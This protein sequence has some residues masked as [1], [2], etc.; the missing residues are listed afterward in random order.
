M[1]EVSYATLFFALLVLWA[2]GV[3]L[4]APK[5]KRFHKIFIAFAV[6]GVICLLGYLFNLWHYLGRPPFRTLGETRLWYAFLLTL[7]GLGVYAYYR[8]AWF[9]SYSLAMSLLFLFIN[10]RHQEVFDKTLMPAL[11]S[12]WFIPHVV[13]YIEAYAL[14]AAATLVALRAFL[15]KDLMGSENIQIADRL[16]RLGY[17]FLMMGLVFGAWWAKEAWGHYWTWDPKETWALITWLCYLIYLHVRY[18]YSERTNIAYAFLL[19]SFLILLVAWF[20]VNYLPNAN[21]SVHT[22]GAS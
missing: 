13:V 6:L 15:K 18:Y 17:A 9:L 2:P 22:Y 12:P 8:L 1:I 14:L 21:L 5:L 19:I 7:A 11:Q 3:M 20:G 4:L 10:F 16:V